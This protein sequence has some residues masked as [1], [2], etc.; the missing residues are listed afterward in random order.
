MWGKEE[1]RHAD[2]SN[3][4]SSHTEKCGEKRK[5]DR[6][7]DPIQDTVIQRNMGKRGKETGRQIQDPVTQRRVVK[8]KERKKIK[9]KTHTK[10]TY[11]NK[12]KQAHKGIHK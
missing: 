5:G 1:R 6:Q 4:R 7:I 2:R 3:S 10:K 12:N 9:T 11:K 8:W